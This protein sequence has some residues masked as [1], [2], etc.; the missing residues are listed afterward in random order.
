[1]AVVVVTCARDVVDAP[2]SPSAAVM[3]SVGGAAD[4]ARSSEAS[5]CWLACTV[6]LLSESRD[7]TPMATMT[8]AT[9]TAAATVHRRGRR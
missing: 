3:A 7:T 5:P 4:G 6:V 9:A 1:L 8:A 2:T